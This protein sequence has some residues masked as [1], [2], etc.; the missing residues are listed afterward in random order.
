V[1]PL[2]AVSPNGVTKWCHQTAASPHG[3]ASLTA[4]VSPL[5]AAS[6]NGVMKRRR[7]MKA[8]HVTKRRHVTNGCRIPMGY[9]VTKPHHETALSLHG[10]TSPMGH[11]DAA[12]P[13]GQYYA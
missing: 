9:Y 1:F 13:I 7:D 8:C 2:A 3:A 11:L 4:A 12:L 5:A 6:T 10:A